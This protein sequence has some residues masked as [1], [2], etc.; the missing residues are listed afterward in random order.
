MVYVAVALAKLQISTESSSGRS[1]TGS[2]S[3]AV[4]CINMRFRLRS[5]YSR[6]IMSGFDDGGFGDGWMVRRRKAK[7][8]TK[9]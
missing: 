1:V 4:E 3:G 7:D 5:M 6:R 9:D 2:C 8:W